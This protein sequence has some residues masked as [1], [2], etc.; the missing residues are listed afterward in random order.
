[1][2]TEPL[3]NTTA[4]PQWIALPAAGQRCQISGLKRGKLLSLATQ[5]KI[6][7]SHLREQGAK[8]GCRLIEVESLLRFIEA[9]AGEVEA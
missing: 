1:M 6:R 9:N 7:C 5:K 8:R 4:L 2:T 3:N